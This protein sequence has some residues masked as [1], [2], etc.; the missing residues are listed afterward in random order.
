MRIVIVGAGEVGS[1]LAA[2]LSKEEQDIILVDKDGEKLDPLD[3]KYNLLTIC[4]HPTSFATLKRADVQHCDLFVAVTPFE[5]DNVTACMIAKGMGAKRT[6][7]RIDNYEYMKE[8]PRAFFKRHGVDSV[9]YPEY[10]AAREIV[11]SLE[12]PWVRRWFEIWNGE[13][14]LLGVKLHSNAA[15]VGMSLRE[16]SSRSHNFHVSAIRRHHDTII[17]DGRTVMEVGDIVYF[18]TRP[19]HVNELREI[20]GK[21]DNK[22]KNIMVMGADRITARLTQAIGGRYK[23]KVVDPDRKRCEKLAEKCSD[24]SVV[25]G[26]ARD[27]DLLFDEN[28]SRMDAFVA[29][30]DSSET[31]IL[32]CL[33]AKEFGVGKTIAE[34][35]SIQYIA[36]AEA[37]NIGTIVNKKL[38]AAGA[39]FQQMLDQDTDNAKVM[40]LADAEVA[41]IEV[42]PGAKVTKGPVKD[43]HLSHDLTIAGLIRGG[44]GQLVDGNTEIE[45]GD[46]VVVFCLNG[47]LHKFEKLF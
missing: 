32:G 22:I 38:L 21:V 2:M 41:D 13:L 19:K 27:N 29:L 24:V 12:H 20:C 35:E 26:D 16:F 3:A 43:L 46:R 11:T 15:I 6:V 40:V 17:P 39:I 8:E 44:V 7:A 42:R 34:V 4:G 10:Y 5:T 37:L 31:N 36:E 30:S 18:M 47:A 25:C 14:I 33:T 45:A 28:I 23:V 1:H 9:I